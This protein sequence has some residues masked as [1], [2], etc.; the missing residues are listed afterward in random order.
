V[1]Y[2]QRTGWS[3][4][5]TREFHSMS[6]PNYRGAARILVDAHGAASMGEAADRAEERLDNIDLSGFAY[7]KRVEGFIRNTM[8]SAR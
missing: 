2:G 1:R 3:T 5:E 6:T 8:H 4:D 7:W